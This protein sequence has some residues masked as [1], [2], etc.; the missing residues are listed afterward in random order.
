MTQLKKWSKE[1]IIHIDLFNPNPQTIDEQVSRAGG[2]AS[3]KGQ[4]YY[5]SGNRSS[6]YPLPKFDAVL[7]DMSTEEGISNI[8]YLNARNNFLPSGMIVDIIDWEKPENEKQI[9]ENE[10]SIE[11]FQGD[12]KT[13]KL[14]Y[15]CAKN[16]DEV[17]VFVKLSGQ[18]YDKEY[19]VTREK[20][21]DDIG[22]SFNQP[23]IL[24]AEDV[25]SNFGADALRNAYD[26]YNSVTEAERLQVERV[27]ARIFKYWNGEPF[28]D[29]GILPLTYKI[30]TPNVKDIP[31]EVISTL[32]VNEK[33]ALIEFGELQDDNSSK[34][35][36]AEKIGAGGVQAMVQIIADPNL[37]AEQKKGTLKLLFSLT[38]EDVESV[39]P[40]QS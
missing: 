14:C 18:N 7:T 23:P 26:Y 30:S 16:K 20:T 10:K 15:S 31:Q 39:I 8:S 11:E 9:E 6:N 28:N 2:W 25:G 19:T 33:R 38:D 32:T 35:L 36:L 21:K 29:F 1:D 22:R 24:R 12:E 5:Y 27:F 3:Y 37:S 40:S 4:V 34:S 17:P 13:G